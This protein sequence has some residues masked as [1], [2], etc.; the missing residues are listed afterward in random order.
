MLL[1]IELCI[2]PRFSAHEEKC[3]SPWIRCSTITT[4]G[5]KTKKLISKF[6]LLKSMEHVTMTLFF[7]S[8]VLILCFSC[9]ATN[10]CQFNLSHTSIRQHTCSNQCFMT[11][12]F[13]NTNYQGCFVEL[14]KILTL[15]RTL[16]FKR[17]LTHSICWHN[18]HRTLNIKQMFS[19]VLLSCTK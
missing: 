1:N 15:I 4:V 17:V 7:F 3:L 19:G 16:D 14:F 2:Q 9:I 8:S 11:S 5:L 6:L 12:W 18:I 10:I 13:M